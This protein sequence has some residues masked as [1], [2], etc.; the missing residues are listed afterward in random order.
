VGDL[1]F[2]KNVT[3]IDN[4]EDAVI[5]VRK[6]YTKLDNLSLEDVK[7]NI[8]F[9]INYCAVQVGA[10]TW[11]TSITDFAKDFPLL[12][13]KVVMIQQKNFNRFVM[14][15]TF[16]DLDSAIALQKKCM[17][18]YHSVPDTFV[19]VYDMNNK[20][21]IIYFDYAKNSFMMLKPEDQFQDDVLFK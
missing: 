8:N 14:R 10:F 6:I 5:G 16:E 12:S 7:K 3:V 13:D 21:V 9:E 20:R 19:A 17:I 2:N 1:S 15:E 4:K 11:K 18:E